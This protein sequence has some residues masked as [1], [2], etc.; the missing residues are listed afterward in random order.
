MHLRISP[1]A[2]LTITRDS[3]G[4]L[5]NEKRQPP[6]HL[7]RV[8]KGVLDHNG[9]E[10]CFITNILQEDAYLIA[11]WYKQRWEI[12]LFFK[13]IKQHLNASHLVSRTLNGM[14]VMIYMT[15]ITAVLLLAYR[16]I[17]RLQGYKIAKLRFEIELE[18]DIIKTIVVLCGGD[19]N[20]APHLFPS[21]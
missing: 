12:E 16:K 1:G 6:K 18:A 9:E 7:C 10:I 17:N 11:P 5:F 4:Y 20:K 8:I 2:T 3:Q 19:S 21:G 15:M 14:K 13:F